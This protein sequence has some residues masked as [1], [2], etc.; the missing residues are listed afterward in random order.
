MVQ[1][2]ENKRINGL[3]CAGSNV[4]LLLAWCV[5]NGEDSAYPSAGSVMAMQSL[6]AH[7]PGITYI[8]IAQEAVKLADELIF[9]LSRI[10]HG[11]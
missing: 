3:G 5:M 2:R 10:G 6:A 9:E 7:D 4:F 1:N 8:T 11:N